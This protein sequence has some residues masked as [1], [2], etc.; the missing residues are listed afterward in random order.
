MQRE[1][2]RGGATCCNVAFT[3]RGQMWHETNS[4]PVICVWDCCTWALQFTENAKDEFAIDNV[5]LFRL[6]LSLL[7]LCWRVVLYC[8]TQKIAKRSTKCAN[9]WHLVSLKRVFVLFLLRIR[10]QDKTWNDAKFDTL[11]IFS[12]PDSPIHTLQQ[13]PQRFTVLRLFHC[14]CILNLFN[15]LQVIHLEFLE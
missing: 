6:L 12:G 5:F 14:G 11:F 4:F 8:A 13:D 7:C 2:I 3:K 10:R 9:C 15:P 1:N